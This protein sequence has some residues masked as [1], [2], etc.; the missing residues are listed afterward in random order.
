MSARGYQLIFR[1]K[2]LSGFPDGS[3][4]SF[5][6]LCLNAAAESQRTRANGPLITRTG[7]PA[8]GAGHERLSPAD[9]GHPGDAQATWSCHKF[10]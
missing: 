7:P 4:I 10:T 3:D 6:C 9:L 2:L 5:V 1:K 8:A